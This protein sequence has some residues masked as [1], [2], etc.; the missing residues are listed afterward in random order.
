MFV[1]LQQLQDIPRILKHK[2]DAIAFE[3]VPHSR[4]I[5]Y[6][7][8]LPAVVN[9]RLSEWVDGGIWLAHNFS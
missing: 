3:R 1:F 8:E 9:D 6:I 5:N 7:N 2:G 4:K